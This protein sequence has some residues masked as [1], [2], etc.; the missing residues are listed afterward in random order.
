[1]RLGGYSTAKLE[2]I[3]P[4]D[5]I[6]KREEMKD[7]GGGKKNQGLEKRRRPITRA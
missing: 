3:S 5:R 4:G 7:K 6:T 1:M 2:E